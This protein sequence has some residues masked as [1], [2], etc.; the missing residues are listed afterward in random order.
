MDGL[1]TIREYKNEEE[2]V[3]KE[4]A[5][6]RSQIRPFPLQ[7]KFTADDT[8]VWDGGGL[9]ANAID[10]ILRL[11]E[12]EGLSITT[13]SPWSFITARNSAAIPPFASQE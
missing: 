3:I 8:S 13:T 12:T 11:E 1:W 2:L 5:N 4:L 10:E 6:P 9:D 7:P